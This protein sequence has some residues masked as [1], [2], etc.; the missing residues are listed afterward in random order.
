[1]SESR[2]PL[3]NMFPNVF[4]R[5]ETPLL[6]EAFRL[7]WVVMAAQGPSDGM[8]EKQRRLANAIVAVASSGV[9]DPRTLADRALERCAKG[10]F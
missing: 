9:F 8:E 5:S 3:S 6:R 4:D 10:L 2:D 7:A 1:M